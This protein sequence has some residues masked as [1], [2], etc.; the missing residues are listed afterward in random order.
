MKFKNPGVDIRTHH[1]VSF[2]SKKI[3]TFLRNAKKKSQLDDY[4]IGW[5]GDEGDRMLACLC[6]SDEL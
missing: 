1:T 5:E 6:T 4:R 3:M 2:T